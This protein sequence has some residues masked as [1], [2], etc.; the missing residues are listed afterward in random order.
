[1]KVRIPKFTR[2]SLFDGVERIVL[3]H[4]RDEQGKFLK[5]RPVVA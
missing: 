5:V 1:M 3:E 4:D 2:D